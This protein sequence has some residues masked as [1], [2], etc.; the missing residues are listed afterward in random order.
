MKDG[1]CASTDDCVPGTECDAGV[2]VPLTA[3]ET[4]NFRCFGE[5]MCVSDGTVDGYICVDCPLGQR[6]TDDHLACLP[7]V[8]ECPE[9][10]L[11]QGGCDAGFICTLADPDVL[12][13]STDVEL[14]CTAAVDQCAT[15]G[16]NPCWTGTDAN[17]D[18]AEAVCV[19]PRPVDEDSDDALCSCPL[20]SAGIPWRGD[21]TAEGFGCS[22][23]VDQCAG[24]DAPTCHVDATCNDASLYFEDSDAVL[25]DCNA[26]FYGDGLPADAVL[27]QVGCYLLADY[28]LIDKI[29]PPLS[30]DVPSGTAARFGG[31]LYVIASPGGWANRLQICDVCDGRAAPGGVACGGSS[32]GAG[33]VDG[34]VSAADF[35]PGHNAVTGVV[36]VVDHDGDGE[37]VRAF[38]GP[39]A[40]TTDVTQ[41]PSP[42]ELTLGVTCRTF[43]PRTSEIVEN[44]PHWGAA[45][46]YVTKAWTVTQD[47][48][49]AEPSTSLSWNWPW[50]D[51]R[52]C[53]HKS[54]AD[55]P[56]ADGGARRR[57]ALD[58]GSPPPL[59][60]EFAIDPT[61]TAACAGLLRRSLAVGEDGGPF[62]HAF[63]VAS[64]GSYVVAAGR[65]EA[66]SADHGY[67]AGNKIYLYHTTGAAAN[68]A[69]EI[70]VVQPPF[71]DAT[72][73]ATVFS[74]PLG[75]EALALVEPSVFNATAGAAQ[76]EPSGLVLAETARSVKAGAAPVL[77]DAHSEFRSP[78]NNYRHTFR[79]S[80]WDFD[81]NATPPQPTS[82][83]PSWLWSSADLEALG[84][85]N[86]SVQA[87]LDAAAGGAC[88]VADCGAG[89][90]CTPSLFTEEVVGATIDSAGDVVVA[91][92]VAVPCSGHYS[93]VADEMNAAKSAGLVVV[94]TRD[95]NGDL[96]PSAI[97][98]GAPD[99]ALE[100]L[101][102]GGL[103]GGFGHAV[104]VSA[105]GTRLVVSAYQD[106]HTG[107]ATSGCEGRVRDRVLVY[108]QSATA[109]VGTV[110][111]G[112]APCW[113]MVQ[114][115]DKDPADCVCDCLNRQRTH[116]GRSL[117]LTPDGL[118][119]V[120]GA[121]LSE[122]G[123]AH[124]GV[125]YA[126]SA[127]ATSYRWTGGVFVEQYPV[128][129]NAHV[130]L[131][132]PETD[133]CPNNIACFFA[134]SI[135]QST[136]GVLSVGVERGGRNA[137]TGPISSAR[138]VF[139]KTQP[140]AYAYY[141][142][143]S[144]NLLL[145]DTAA[146]APGDV[147]PSSRTAAITGTHEHAAGTVATDDITFEYF[148]QADLTMD[149]P[150][151]NE[152][153]WLGYKVVVW[154]RA[155]E[156]GRRVLSGAPKADY[157]P[158]NSGPVVS[159]ADG[160]E[161]DPQPA[162]LVSAGK[163][164]I[165]ERQTNIGYL[166][167][168]VLFSPRPAQGGHFGTSMGI[169][170]E[171]LAVAE[172][173][174][175]EADADEPLALGRVH[176]LQYDQVNDQWLQHGA[177][178]GH[179]VPYDTTSS[180]CSAHH[181][182]D[183]DTNQWF[184][185]GDCAAP[186]TPKH[187]RVGDQFGYAQ[188]SLSI[189]ASSLWLAVGAPAAAGRRGEVALMKYDSV[190]GCWNIRE[191]PLLSRA[192][193]GDEGDLFGTSTALNY[194]GN[195]LLVGAPG[196]DGGRGRIKRLRPDPTIAFQIVVISTPW[197]D[198]EGYL[199]GVGPTMD[200]WLYPP[201][202]LPDVRAFG[203]SID[204]SE[205]G[206]VIAVGAPGFA[207]TALAGTQTEGHA[208]VF[209]RD[210]STNAWSS[211]IEVL[212]DPSYAVTNPGGRF[213][214]SVALGVRGRALAVGQT[215]G[216]YHYATRAGAVFNFHLR[217]S[218]SDGSDLELVDR[219]GQARHET[220]NLFGASV[221]M[222]ACCS[223][224]VFEDATF[225]RDTTFILDYSGSMGWSD[226]GGL[227]T[228][229]ELMVSAMTAM[230]NTFGPRDTATIIP[231]SRN[232]E[233]C[234]QL[235]TCET[236][237]TTPDNI[238][239]LIDVVDT[240]NSP[241]GGTDFYY[242]F[243]YAFQVA[244]ATAESWI[245]LGELEQHCT[246]TMLFLT[247]GEDCSHKGGGMYA[248]DTTQGFN[249][250]HPEYRAIF[251]GCF[252]D[253]DGDGILTGIEN[254]VPGPNNS[255]QNPGTCAGSCL[256]GGNL[257]NEG[258]S[259]KDGAPCTCEQFHYRYGYANNST[260]R[261]NVSADLWQNFTTSCSL[262]DP[263][264]YPAGSGQ[265]L[266]YKP[267]WYHTDQA[268]A[269]ADG[270]DVSSPGWSA[271]PMDGPDL[272]DGI[273]Y[274]Q[275]IYEG[276]TGSRAKIFTY[277]MSSGADPTVPQRIAA[278]N[279]G[280]FEAIVNGV[281]PLEQMSKYKSFAA[282]D[283]KC[284]G[285][286][287]IGSDPNCVLDDEVLIVGAPYTD[288][289][290]AA[291]VM[292]DKA[293]ETS[294]FSRGTNCGLYPPVVVAQASPTK[295]C[296]DTCLGVD[297]YLLDSEKKESEFSDVYIAWTAVDCVDCREPSREEMIACVEDGEL[298]TPNI[299]L[300]IDGVP[301]CFL[302]PWDST[303][304]LSTGENWTDYTSIT[305]LNF[306]TEYRTSLLPV[307]LLEGDIVHV[308][309]TTPEPPPIVDPVMTAVWVPNADVTVRRGYADVDGLHATM[310]VD[311]T[312][313]SNYPTIVEWS[314]WSVDAAGVKL[315]VVFSGEWSWDPSSCAAPCNFTIDFGSSQA[316]GVGSGLADDGTAY[317]IDLV[318][319]TE[320]HN[321]VDTGACCAIEVEAA[322]PPA[323]PVA[324]ADLVAA[325]TTW[326][327]LTW[328]VEVDRSTYPLSRY[329]HYVVVA[330]AELANLT[331]AGDEWETAFAC[332]TIDALADPSCINIA[333]AGRIE[334][335]TG[336]ATTANVAVTGLDPDTAY[337]LLAVPVLTEC[338][339]D[340]PAG[341]QWGTLGAATDECWTSGLTGGKPAQS[342]SW[343]DQSTAT[344][345]SPLAANE[346]FPG[347]GVVVASSGT[348]APLP[349]L[350]VQ[351]VA[352]GAAVDTTSDGA[353][354]V[355]ASYEV[356]LSESLPDGDRVVDVYWVAMP[357]SCADTPTDSGFENLVGLL[358]TAWPAPGWTACPATCTTATQC[359][360]GPK[361][362]DQNDGDS[363]AVDVPGLPLEASYT[364]VAIPVV[365]TFAVDG[366]DSCPADDVA[367]W[368]PLTLTA[369][370]GVDCSDLTVPNFGSPDAADQATPDWIPLVT[371]TA[372]TT[373][374]SLTPSFV[375]PSIGG[376][377]ADPAG[378]RTGTTVRYVILPSS[379]S[380]PSYADVI[381]MADDPAT[382]APS[383][384]VDVDPADPV[385]PVVPMAN[386]FGG[387]DEGRS[388][389][390]Y[391][392][393]QVAPCSGPGSGVEEISPEA[394]AMISGSFVTVDTAPQAAFV[395][396][397]LVA[398]HDS[399]SV[400]AGVIVDPDV[401]NH[402]ADD[403]EE[404]SDQYWILYSAGTI[405]QNEV[406][407]A[408]M[409]TCVERNECA[410]AE[411]ATA[412][413]CP[414]LPAYPV[415]INAADIIA[416]G[417]DAG[418]AHGDTDAVTIE[419][420]GA[421]A[422][423]EGPA[424]I[425]P[426]TS[427]TIATVAASTETD[428]VWSGVE[429][430][431]P[432]AFLDVLTPNV[433]TVDFVMAH[434]TWNSADVDIRL[435]DPVDQAPNDKCFDASEFLCD[436]SVDPIDCDCQASTHWF[437]TICAKKSDGT[438][439]CPSTPPSLETVF[440]CTRGA[441]GDGTDVLS[442]S[443]GTPPF[444]GAFA[445]GKESD[446]SFYLPDLTPN[447]FYQVTAY[448]QHP[449]PIDGSTRDVADGYSPPTTGVF[450]TLP[451][452]TD[453][454][455]VVVN[456][457]SKNTPQPPNP[458]P[459]GPQNDV[460]S[461]TF[462][463]TVTSN[464]DDY[465]SGPV[466]VSWALFNNYDSGAD[467]C[468]SPAPS[469]MLSWQDIVLCATPDGDLTQSELDTKAALASAE[470]GQGRF[471]CG[472]TSVDLTAVTFSDPLDPAATVEVVAPGL[473]HGDCFTVVAVPQRDGSVGWLPDGTTME[474]QECLDPAWL[475]SGAASDPKDAR[476]GVIIPHVT[477]FEEDLTM[478][479]SQAAMSYTPVAHPSTGDLYA[480]VDVLADVYWALV[481]DQD[482][483]NDPNLHPC[484]GNNG[485]PPSIADLR[486]V[487]NSTLWTDPVTCGPCG[488]L[489]F[490]DTFGAVTGF[491]A[492]DDLVACADVAW[493]DPTSAE[494]GFPTTGYCW[495]MPD[496]GDFPPST[497]Y[498]WFA[499]PVGEKDTP[500]PRFVGQFRTPDPPVIDIPVGDVWAVDITDTSS[501]VV[502]TYNLPGNVTMCIQPASFDD[503]DVSHPAF[504]PPSQYPASGG[505]QAPCFFTLD[506]IPDGLD[507]NG[508]PD[509]SCD[510]GD[511]DD[512]PRGT[513][514][515]TL[516]VP[517]E[518]RNYDIPLVWLT[519]ATEYE[520]FTQ[521][522]DDDAVGAFAKDVFTTLYYDGPQCDT[523]TL[524][525]ADNYLPAITVSKT[526]NPGGED[527]TTAFSF[528]LADATPGTW[529]ADNHP[530]N[531]RVTY[532][533]V[534]ISQI[535]TVGLYKDANGQDLLSWPT[536]I[537][538]MTLQC[539]ACFADP[540]LAT[541]G[542]PDDPCASVSEGG[543]TYSGAVAAGVV[544]VTAVVTSH[545]VTITGLEPH[546][547]PANYYVVAVPNSADEGSTLG[548]CTATATDACNTGCTGFIDV[549]QTPVQSEVQVTP[550][551]DG[552][553]VTA[554]PDCYSE[555][556]A[557]LALTHDAD[558]VWTLFRTEDW[559]GV[560][561]VSSQQ[562]ILRDQMIA[563][564]NDP[565]SC[566]SGLLAGS[567]YEDA[568]V[569]MGQPAAVPS[570]EQWL[571]DLPDLLSANPSSPTRYTVVAVALRNED[572]AMIAK[573]Q[574]AVWSD[575]LTHDT[576]QPPVRPPISPSAP[577]VA[578][579]QTNVP[580]LEYYAVETAIRSPPHDVATTAVSWILVPVGVAATNA[581]RAAVVACAAEWADGNI[582]A[583]AS[584]AAWE[585]SLLGGKAV[586]NADD[587]YYKSLSTDALLRDGWFTGL[588]DRVVG[589]NEGE[590]TVVMVPMTPAAAT[591]NAA[592]VD[593][594][595]WDFVG[596]VNWLGT[597]PIAQ[598]NAVTK[599][600][601]PPVPQYVSDTGLSSGGASNG[602]PSGE[603]VSAPSSFELQWQFQ[604]ELETEIGVGGIYDGLPVSTPGATD[605][606]NNSFTDYIVVQ[607]ND[608]PSPE[609]LA[610]YVA[611]I[612]C[613][614]EFGPGSSTCTG[615]GSI[616][617]DLGDQPGTTV[618][619]KEAQDALSITAS[620][621]VPDTTYYLIGIPRDVDDASLQGD[622]FFIPGQTRPLY[623]P[624]APVV[625]NL[626]QNFGDSCGQGV[627]CQDHD[628]FYADYSLETNSF[629]EATVFYALTLEGE[630]VPT[631]QEVVKCGRDAGTSL[632]L[633][634]NHLSNASPPK[635]MV[636]CGVYDADTLTEMGLSLMQMEDSVDNERLYYD[637]PTYVPILPN[638]AYHWTLV[639]QSGSAVGQTE[640]VWEGSGQAVTTVLRTLAADPEAPDT[641]TV[642]DG[643]CVDGTQ[644]RFRQTGLDYD[645]LRWTD[646]VEATPNLTVAYVL[647][648][649][650]TPAPGRDSCG[651]P[652]V[653]GGVTAQDVQACALAKVD[654]LDVV[655]L[656]DNG[657]GPHG[658]TLAAGT[659]ALPDASVAGEV[660]NGHDVTVSWTCDAF[661]DCKV[662]DP[663]TDAIIGRAAG[664]AEEP[665]VLVGDT[666]YDLY[667]VAYSSN[668]N[669]IGLGP[670]NA[671]VLEPYRLKTGPDP[672]RVNGW[673]DA[674]TTDTDS[675]GTTLT[676][677]VDG[678]VAVALLPCDAAV[679]DPL[680]QAF[681]DS[682]VA[683]AHDPQLEAGGSIYNNGVYDKNN[684]DTENSWISFE[685]VEAPNQYSDPPTNAACNSPHDF[686]A[687]RVVTTN[688]GE[689][690]GMVF[691]GLQP[692]TCYNTYLVIQNGGV[693]GL[694]DG[695]TDPAGAT[696]SGAPLVSVEIIEGRTDRLP[697]DPVAPQITLIEQT[698]ED[699]SAFASTAELPWNSV[700]VELS[701][702]KQAETFWILLPHGSNAPSWWQI[703]ACED[704]ANGDVDDSPI[705]DLPVVSLL[706]GGGTCH[707]A[708]DE[709]G[710]GVCTLTG[711]ATDING[712]PINGGAGVSGL[713]PNT[714]YDLWAVPESVPADCASEPGTD[715]CY[716][717]LGEV[718]MGVVQTGPPPP[719][720]PPKRPPST[721]PLPDPDTIDGNG[722][723]VPQAE[724]QSIPENGDFEYIIRYGASNTVVSNSPGQRGE[725]IVVGAAEDTYGVGS[726]WLLKRWT[727]AGPSGV[728]EFELE[729]FYRPAGCAPEAGGAFPLVSTDG[730]EVCPSGLGSQH[731][732]ISAQ[733]GLGSPT[734]GGRV[735]AVGAPRSSVDGLPNA[736]A[737]YLFTYDLAS[738]GV[739][740][741]AAVLTAKTPQANALFGVSTGITYGTVDAST[742]T[743][744]YASVL[745][746]GSPGADRVE[747][748]RWESA[749]VTVAADGVE[750]WASGWSHAGVIDVTGVDSE[751]VAPG[752]LFG[753]DLSVSLDG[754]RLAVGAPL[755]SEATGA[756]HFYQTALD[757]QTPLTVPGDLRFSKL[758]TGD[759]FG[760]AFGHAVDL[761]F[762]GGVMAVGAPGFMVERPMPNDSEFWSYSD[763]ILNDSAPMWELHVGAAH[764]YNTESAG[765]A[766]RDTVLATDGFA[767]WPNPEGQR[768]WPSNPDGDMF[769]FSIDLNADG[770]V[771][772]V[773]APKLDFTFSDNDA[774]RR[775]TDAASVYT[776]ACDSTTGWGDCGGE[777]TSGGS[778]YMYKRDA[779]NVWTN[780]SEVRLHSDAY[781]HPDDMIDGVTN[782]GSRL[783]YSV[784]VSDNSAVQAAGG[785][786][787]DILQTVD[788]YGNGINEP[789]TGVRNLRERDHGRLW[790]W[791]GDAANVSCPR[792]L[793]DNAAICYSPPTVPEPEVAVVSP[794]PPAEPP[795]VIEPIW[796]PDV[797]EE[798]LP[799]CSTPLT[800]APME[801]A[802][803]SGENA[804]Q[805]YGA[806]FEPI[807]GYHVEGIDSGVLSSPVSVCD[808]PVAQTLYLQ[809]EEE[810]T[811]GVSPR[812]VVFL[813]TS[814]VPI[815]TGKTY[816]C[817]TCGDDKTFVESLDP[818]R[819]ETL[820]GVLTK[821]DFSLIGYKWRLAPLT[822]S[823]NFAEDDLAPFRRRSSTGYGSRGYGGFG[824]FQTLAFFDDDGATFYDSPVVP[825]FD[826][827]GCNANLDGEGSFD[828][829]SC[830]PNHLEGGLTQYLLFLTIEENYEGPA[831]VGINP[832]SQ[833]IKSNLYDFRTNPDIVAQCPLCQL[834][835]YP[836]SSMS[837]IERPATVVVDTLPPTALLR[838]TD[839]DPV[840]PSA[841]QVPILYD[842]V[843]GKYITTTVG[844]DLVF[845]EL[846]V[847]TKGD[848]YSALE[849]TW[850]DASADSEVAVPVATDES[851]GV[852]GYA[853]IADV[854]YDFTKGQM[855]FSFTSDQPG[856]LTIKFPACATTDAFG[857][858]NNE[859]ELALYFELVY[860][861][862]ET[863]TTATSTVAG[864]ALV[865]G[866]I[867]TEGNIAFA[868]TGGLATYAR[869]NA[870][871]NAFPEETSSLSTAL[872][873]GLNLYS[874]NL[875]MAGDGT[876]GDNTDE[877]M[878]TFR[879]SLRGI[880][881]VRGL[882]ESDGLEDY[883]AALEAR[884]DDAAAAFARHLRESPLAENAPRLLVRHLQSLTEGDLHLIT[885]NALIDARPRIVREGFI[886]DALRAVWPNAAPRRRAASLVA[887]PVGAVSRTQRPASPLDGRRRAQ[888]ADAAD[889]AGAP[890]VPEDFLTLQETEARTV[891]RRVFYSIAFMIILTS[892]HGVIAFLSMR[893]AKP[894]QGF[895]A[896]PNMELWMS[897]FLAP[898]LALSA[899]MLF[900]S[901]SYAG[902]L[903]AIIILVVL[904]MPVIA[905]CLYLMYTTQV[906]SD[907]MDRTIY[908]EIRE[909]EL[910]RVEAM[911]KAGVRPRFNGRLGWLGIGRATPVGAWNARD[912]EGK[913]ML[914]R[915]GPIFTVF[916]GPA[917]MR[918]GCTF[919]INAFASRF[920]R[921]V[922][923]PFNYDAIHGR[924][925][926][927]GYVKCFTMAWRLGTSVAFCVL[928][929][930]R[931]MMNEVVRSGLM[932]G[933]FVFV[934]AFNAWVQPCTLDIDQFFES[935]GSLLELIT[936]TLLFLTHL[937]LSFLTAA[938]DRLRFGSGMGVALF[939]VMAINV[940]SQ[941]FGNWSLFHRVVAAIPVLVKKI[942]PFLDKDSKLKKAISAEIKRAA[943]GKDDSVVVK[944][945]ANRWLNHTLGQSLQ[946]WPILGAYAP[947][948]L[949]FMF[950]EAFEG[951]GFDSVDYV[952]RIRAADPAWIVRHR[953]R[954][955]YMSRNAMMSALLH[956]HGD[957]L[958][959]LGVPASR[960][961]VMTRMNLKAARTLVVQ[962]ARRQV[963][964]LDE[965]LAIE[966]CL[967]DE[968]EEAS[969]EET[970][971]ESSWEEVSEEEES[972]SESDEPEPEEPAVL[973]Q[974]PGPVPLPEPVLVPPPLVKPKKPQP[975]PP[976]RALKKQ[977][978]QEGQ[979]RGGCA[980]P[981]PV[982]RPLGHPSPPPSRPLSAPLPPLPPPPSTSLLNRTRT[983]SSR[984]PAPTAW[985]Q[986][987]G[988]GSRPT[989]L[990]RRP[991]A[992]GGGRAGATA[993]PGRPSSTRTP[994]GAR[995]EGTRARC[996]R[997]TPS[998]WSEG[999]T[1000]AAAAA[1001]GRP[1002]RRAR[1003]PGGESRPRGVRRRRSGGPGRGVRPTPSLRS[1004][1005]ERER[1006]R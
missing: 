823:D 206:S 610:I 843:T 361:A 787:Y 737:V 350:A 757:G 775:L 638:S 588:D 291:S 537:S 552:F 785:P 185:S 96:Q 180:A 546:V 961:I 366:I 212:P 820:H 411:A 792:T 617:V 18:P 640:N 268:T 530:G 1003:R 851:D 682:V 604:I 667:L 602:I 319:V 646:F 891:M 300:V 267:V 306:A 193:G 869:S 352:T 381:M 809:G 600:L 917:V 64:S 995:A 358:Q 273:N 166:P 228:R 189:S 631:W 401:T 86:P 4:G 91:G 434:P 611:Y 887:G 164:V 608:D 357:T 420:A 634:A 650:S 351:V 467:R 383:G 871:S 51:R 516:L 741:P 813:F 35:F 89:L 231:F 248:Y 897:I 202:G 790:I 660:L 97:L 449:D 535:T 488:C 176:V 6:A 566:G 780:A 948:E 192:D 920:Q 534:P 936:Y 589:T 911:R 264:R 811:C 292:M 872:T 188:N 365:S 197:F 112:G 524:G 614:R 356:Q 745:W 200:G 288:V 156:G 991:A 704:L 573:G 81:G 40:T 282:S 155:A 140:V 509:G 1:A 672:P 218:T 518:S 296:P 569:V 501:E 337:T 303:S 308:L 593:T 720:P 334:F 224:G 979:R 964:P 408:L 674:S 327:R 340:L 776:A 258:T 612:N 2:C 22:F 558:V 817:S 42:P 142:N 132:G 437:V 158:P 545:V 464:E 615:V 208:F 751:P 461:V 526:A 586:I 677:S 635:T 918:V 219:V 542:G 211:V 636:R 191:T 240:A 62:G 603:V 709:D 957:V 272:L 662:R 822:K 484:T 919:E 235:D 857:N 926:T 136:F 504:N 828:G 178:P 469:D 100:D 201:P 799:A 553:F 414:V 453:Q 379:D 242:A 203:S 935:L 75:R 808:A 21:G 616:V 135:S 76:L 860:V 885:S 878:V 852:I 740:H 882:G 407:A 606:S 99:P 474:G 482:P 215:H 915:F 623:D 108:E 362:S 632:A 902:V 167:S 971:D 973:P 845:D 726:V 759:R 333:A 895:L 111:I 939:C 789:A 804:F 863:V 653:T 3:C 457:D 125:R 130:T 478:D 778:A 79:L 424:L 512:E 415:G 439:D 693:V 710:D 266:Q 867:R 385:V 706:G 465:T 177:C 173:F 928:A 243:M 877:F 903:L 624:D 276:V 663:S 301:Q 451:C 271:V 473:E 736:G 613:Q 771:M 329:L 295:P 572:E 579:Q 466:V 181:I 335:A 511:L 846:V 149:A 1001:E 746:V 806:T 562:D 113:K 115:L 195:T 937:G 90:S 315:A 162:S 326:E 739:L 718:K 796:I 900:T 697:Y 601:P 336:D 5:R 487:T 43:W 529:G 387:L 257:G 854:A 932:A 832:A 618:G 506:K 609:D 324:T 390:V 57:S 128:L 145:L 372:T 63:D 10:R 841:S 399:I 229:D 396:S 916:G 946:D 940:L 643:V 772:V 805:A 721:T 866:G 853:P 14:G 310:R 126:D 209:L 753:L 993:L 800:G 626:H 782:W 312:L 791:H 578:G 493:T 906:L 581:D 433:M 360:V 281:S 992:A 818:Q 685:N 689:V 241:G 627:L 50:V 807:R 713:T 190:G 471:V 990:R 649:V 393:P 719:P 583:D 595:S 899:G 744:E 199:P 750:D 309:Q 498:N 127:L 343:Y 752:S 701:T 54:P 933:L 715:A 621:L 1005:L 699:G 559:E 269:A 705:C 30:R 458:Y 769:G 929:G 472:R 658:F 671:L 862:P 98:T 16:V 368:V 7:V 575:G 980:G 520:I 182:L 986:P 770:S 148:T 307:R 642:A 781:S 247:D 207:S 400:S 550:V 168:R 23:P 875:P 774:G 283:P 698:L 628:H 538:T 15:A 717:G 265:A 8:D 907:S 380:A 835:D 975:G 422:G 977:A 651:Y 1006:E 205:D 764:V 58:V 83:A 773:G 840:S 95:A 941:V 252:Y 547:N 659:V 34:A 654:N 758:Y 768:T 825:Y 711:T 985:R 815:P 994:R 477:N 816:H 703:M 966:D 447:T 874:L 123:A 633:A 259:G 510:C 888:A 204:V 129:A 684:T 256:G 908:F 66:I 733:H 436:T 883:F 70:V 403:D 847:G 909:R 25:C 599:P 431:G 527:P 298:P 712:Q 413:A 186:L 637:Q 455:T 237:V 213:G 131:H 102:L 77:G 664:T 765:V 563:C 28:A 967:Y 855:Q 339:P 864:A 67:L 144:H 94:H 239:K 505:V 630:P 227:T 890:L 783:G 481:L 763:Q 157:P 723:A 462:T 236:L 950:E 214:V 402:E 652:I 38:A 984:C 784:G 539:Q 521:V 561:G 254:C 152:G 347:E 45:Y 691:D 731:G 331:S 557:N 445:V 275:E 762:N 65:T 777:V 48:S 435:N 754:S 540:S 255:A 732:S 881:V 146:P 955:W 88:P 694:V 597:G 976:A 304:S 779:S 139:P 485:D 923:V 522:W 953:E 330:D 110:C 531:F 37:V 154:T 9:P 708:D 742:E 249:S 668:D 743:E 836:S 515:G 196:M 554:C 41:T 850:Q 349:T 175:N 898:I 910:A 398:T 680:D 19:D 418:V 230:L 541:C 584:C 321:T 377:V 837:N 122:V 590:Y 725:W 722:V 222:A 234:G 931:G 82:A 106:R 119:L 456:V 555:A 297:Y 656:C 503:L 879:R 238:A 101:G 848:L 514:C 858:G 287:R 889:S 486:A 969:E 338:W 688:F 277:A 492:A 1004:E 945:Y 198:D 483:G 105:D 443:S 39:W 954:R 831:S 942:F 798:F 179:G 388:Y 12:V 747:A 376:T 93:G 141:R 47:C 905:V 989:G 73:G 187:T 844:L 120:V 133:P 24:I 544:D 968:W 849:W 378:G 392:I 894:L 143:N 829:V 375:V 49:P 639:P 302:D 596:L 80:H 165:Y 761:S 53:D 313:T 974:A 675:I 59:S 528:Q 416:C 489:D 289:E 84:A 924:S 394:G 384:C 788:V 904:P 657:F 159:M 795:A 150:Y 812:D 495:K 834:V 576:F 217:G 884:G 673:H 543:M 982:L 605:N 499:V 865:W 216:T 625:Y 284:W 981:A 450:L 299:F 696:Y 325:A 738:E 184:G 446:L 33:E 970:E 532:V 679:V 797:W 317:L 587:A 856:T 901:G 724:P 494:L 716:Y 44:N 956:E 316:D 29:E 700:Y 585:G 244:T 645:T 470:G 124:S 194:F 428:G 13:E 116:F 172:S 913:A 730:A 592:N 72:D 427:Y 1000:A 391:A 801:A 565:T 714:K 262:T 454:P 727:S 641:D 760:D 404:P 620:G 987:S 78:G 346:Y 648:E 171:Q 107:D 374:T 925:P 444:C 46:S 364:L 497:D 441:A 912:A 951:V 452:P 389:T 147:T 669:T 767:G 274:L 802:R 17:G 405:A 463:V 766:A 320:Y 290:T 311:A 756:V 692:D 232:N 922:L 533:V 448:A 517:D 965:L 459:S 285:T 839:I 410:A 622:G 161:L 373:E 824:Q 397:T 421:T 314:V 810:P 619:T 525:D 26:G 170:D 251:E 305:G 914:D 279:G 280:E 1002:G 210:P 886:A 594:A 395:E 876:D 500:G 250:M 676:T 246:P 830:S 11:V 507:A 491:V 508:D 52:A 859:T 353:E 260:T 921:G 32:A 412:G 121:G 827:D 972:S 978:R 61:D 363:F 27:G 934:F 371:L 647:L 476:T 893:R 117:D 896:F 644:T 794:P 661:A 571:A 423:V 683:C 69:L 221:V 174:F 949:E 734:R 225:P 551:I 417:T 930:Y 479:E 31:D 226:D 253:I 87:A 564:Y 109:G 814:S 440:D 707:D 944:K 666:L 598:F 151:P 68:A 348:T 958:T 892:I 570:A 582:A 873:N 278:N 163:V 496:V 607:R 460:D 749:A 342:L 138:N 502:Q 367:T 629:A 748:F 786:G 821:A 997:R 826:T 332:G 686:L 548:D 293:G 695:D 574:Y 382:A 943:R 118:N 432:V 952:P 556:Q 996:R 560:D 793:D 567:V 370:A 55:A 294:V 960:K 169:A 419:V 755:A 833:L 183:V 354:I 842:T 74:R 938:N 426:N 103:Y 286:L 861:N 819:P 655:T 591:A 513:C 442:S 480:R 438:H 468:A 690:Q 803:Y 36:E 729:A 681:I 947:D 998:C 114:V 536:S 959:S 568:K 263:N 490:N 245:A 963:L 153:E 999:P 134:D 425:R 345:R 160:L 430:I 549:R 92:L 475:G 678:T 56:D 838:R 670:D 220:G 328:D 104:R 665:L 341:T 355:T 735:I 577:T 523:E 870:S 962:A 137:A 71:D 868:V 580:N 344:D 687:A 359:Y 85:A 233:Y 386:G 927:A 409:R 322:T 223:P 728:D 270:L 880:P 60:C 429:Q 519:P 261:G 983:S 406:T 323:P 702:D 988:R 318:P 20:D 369:S